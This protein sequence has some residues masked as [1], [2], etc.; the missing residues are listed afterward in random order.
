MEAFV[1]A[2]RALAATPV[3]TGPG[4]PGGPV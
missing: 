1:S 4:A 2:T 3:P